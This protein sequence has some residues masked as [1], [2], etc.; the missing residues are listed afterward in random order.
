MDEGG[1]IALRLN[2]SISWM[3]IWADS[4]LDLPLASSWVLVHLIAEASVLLA[5]RC[6]EA[7]RKTDSVCLT[8]RSRDD[9]QPCVVKHVDV[10]LV[11]DGSRDAHESEHWTGAG[12][13]QQAPNNN[14]FSRSRAIARRQH[15]ANG[16]IAEECKLT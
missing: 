11:D 4:L 1:E 15:V 10:A 13:M 7:S 12:I 9:P 3:G 14:S 16:V 5:S 8:F 6:A 2:A